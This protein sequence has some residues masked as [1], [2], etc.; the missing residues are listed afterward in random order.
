MFLHALPLLF[1]FDFGYQG[2]IRVLQDLFLNLDVKM[3]GIYFMY[4][5]V[6]CDKQCINRHV[7]LLSI[8][9]YS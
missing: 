6:E 8:I 3:K 9:N 1:I 2:V 4:W 5:P 7:T